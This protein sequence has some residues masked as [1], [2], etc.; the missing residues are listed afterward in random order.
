LVPFQ[1]W[2][3]VRTLGAVEVENVPTAQAL[4][5]EKV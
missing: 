5:V 3:S 2:T 4:L 1:R